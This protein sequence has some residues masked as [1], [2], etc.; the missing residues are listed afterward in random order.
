MHRTGVLLRACRRRRW[1]HRVRNRDRLL[2]R[3]IQ[4]AFR[5][6][7]EA[8]QAVCTT[9]VVRLAVMLKRPRGGLRL[10]RHPADRINFNW[11]CPS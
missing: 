4:K 10:N 2:L 11:F 1:F 5:I 9:E 6:F 7:A 3:A 8:M